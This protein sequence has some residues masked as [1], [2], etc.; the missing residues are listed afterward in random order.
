[1]IDI[2]KIINSTV[3]A[4]PDTQAIYLFGSC[5]ADVESSGSDVDIALLLPHE[6]AK[7]AGNISFS[8][9]FY[10]LTE[11]LQKEIDLINLRLVSTVFQKEIIATGTQLYLTDE[12]AATEF[13]ALILSLYAKLNDERAD[14]LE[15]FLQS[16]RAYQV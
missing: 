4:Y 2:G 10:E 1:M 11:Q 7:K 14:I 16:K 13:E 6:T 5:G 8:S 3:A 15:D 9:L 12:Q